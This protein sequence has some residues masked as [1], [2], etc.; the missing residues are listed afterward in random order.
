MSNPNPHDGNEDIAVAGKSKNRTQAEQDAAD[1]A[2]L[3]E[4][5]DLRQESGITAGMLRDGRAKAI[6]DAAMSSV[7]ARTRDAGEIT[8]AYADLVAAAKMSG[9]DGI[10]PDR[11]FH[12]ENSR[13]SDVLAWVLGYP[14]L[15]GAF[16]RVLDM[17]RTAMTKARIGQ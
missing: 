7:A 11:R 2:Y 13:I 12:D 17:L 4:L 14:D 15:E 5:D 6:M 3:R 10:L 1:L 8:G 9:P 16:A